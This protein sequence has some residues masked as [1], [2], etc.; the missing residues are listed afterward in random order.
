MRVWVG[1]LGS[2]ACALMHSHSSSLSVAIVRMARYNSSHVS[3]TND[4]GQCADSHHGNT[5][6]NVVVTGEFDWSESLQ[7]SIKFTLLQLN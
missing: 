4:T 2:L 7:V 5:N 3:V 1:L 6:D